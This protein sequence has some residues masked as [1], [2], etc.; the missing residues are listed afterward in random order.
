MRLVAVNERG[1]RVNEDHGRA[2]LSDSDVE[3]VL[4]LLE[5]RRML[6]EQYMKVGLARA[7]IWP[8]LRDSQLSYGGI[9]WKFEVSKSLI[10][11][12]ESGRLRST[13]AAR[14]KRVE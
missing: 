2:K 3:L 8:V 9:A 1:N 12:I 4:S 6:I 11:A 5:C 10:R 14:W 13:R 7:N